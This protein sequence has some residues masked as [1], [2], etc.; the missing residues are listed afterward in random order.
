MSGEVAMVAVMT[1]SLASTAF[2]KSSAASK[3]TPGNS[4]WNWSANFRGK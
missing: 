3:R 2:A 1:M 4:R